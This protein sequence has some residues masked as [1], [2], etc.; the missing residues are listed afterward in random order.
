MTFHWAL[1]CVLSHLTFTTTSEIG[2]IIT[3]LHRRKPRQ[4]LVELNTADIYD[5]SLIYAYRYWAFNHE[6]YSQQAM[7][8]YIHK[9]SA[10]EVNTDHWPLGEELQEKKEHVALWGQMLMWQTLAPSIWIL[11]LLTGCAILHKF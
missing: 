7:C 2:I 8:Q 1:K 5:K 11:T 9:C 10:G 3:V 6:C 4:I